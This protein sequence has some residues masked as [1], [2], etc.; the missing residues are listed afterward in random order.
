MGQ[1]HVTSEIGKLKKVLLHRPGK[2]L[3]NLTPDTLSRLLF[4]DI[5]FLPD[6]IKEHDEFAKALRDNGVEVVYLE[7][8][9]AD[10]IA[11]NNNIRAKF[12][13]QFMTEAGINTIKYRMLVEDYLMAIKDPKELVLKTMEGIQVGDIPEKKRDVEKT[14]VDLINSPDEFIADPMPNLYF[15]RDNFA[16]VGDGIDLHRMYSVTRNR[17][18]IYAEYI[19]KYHPDYKDTNLYYN[20]DYA[21][22]TEGGDLLNINDHTVA[23]G[24]SQRTEPAAIDQ[25]AKNYFKDPDCKI[26][27]VLAFNIPSSRAFMHLDTVFTQ[28]DKY[29]FTY[30]PGIMGTLQVFEITEGFDPDTYEDLNVKEINAPLDEI[31]S[32]YLNHP[33]KLIPCAG[34]DKVGAEREQWNDGSNT[35]CIAP[36]TVVVYDRNNVTNDVLRKEGIN[37]IEIHGAELSRGRGGPRCMSM[38]LV[39]EDVEW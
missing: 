33:V 19:F 34:G 32:K 29:T 12:I 36:G 18:T 9:M 13:R 25:L 31:L 27:T 11:L 35:L 26:D 3:L 4:D 6:A 14:L 2:E 37:V 10:V 16:S 7:D 17:E 38:P 24:I 28:I 15:T 21:W 5:P 20:R 23:I 1:I 22:H 39:R 8:L 30:H